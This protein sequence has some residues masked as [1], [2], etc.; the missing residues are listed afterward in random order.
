MFIELG[1]DQTRQYIDAVAV[2]T[3]LEEARGAAASYA[4]AMFARTIRGASYIIRTT[5]SGTQKSLGVLTDENADMV[6]R[7][8]AKKKTAEDRVRSLAQELAKHE[9]LNRALRVGRTPVI[10]VDMLQAIAKAG[11]S[12][13]FR[14][15]GTHALYAYES[16]ASVLIPNDALATRDVDLLLDTRKQVKFLTKMKRLESSFLGVLQKVDK[17]FR[18]RP[19]QLYTA[20]NDKGFE[21]DVIRRLASDKDP[22]PLKRSD[23]EDDFWAVQVSMGERML[24]TRPFEQI[25]ISTSGSMARMRTIHPLDFARLKRELGSLP[26]R[27]PAKYRKDILQAQAITDMVR[28]YLPHLMDQPAPAAPG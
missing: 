14:V 13:H 21:V 17:T 26:F 7:F 22:H 25:V 1:P 3:A 24:S 19:N 12:E 6:E 15:V 23:S 5:P 2:Y 8:N 10:V 11:L 4:G 20:V 28:E 18:L 9:R 16:A 27:D